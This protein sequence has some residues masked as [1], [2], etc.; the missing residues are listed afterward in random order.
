MFFM[1]DDFEKI[2]ISINESI[3]TNK[4][5][6]DIS[7]ILLRSRYEKYNDLNISYFGVGDSNRTVRFYDPNK[8]KKKGIES[9]KYSEIKIGKFIRK[10]LTILGE[11]DNFD[12]KD[13]E[14][15]T[16]TYKSFYD[17]NISRENGFELMS[18]TKG[19]RY[20]YDSHNFE[21]NSGILGGSCMNNLEG[22]VNYYITH[23]QGNLR[24]LVLKN[25]DNK[26]LGRALVWKTDKGL[27]MDRVYTINDS[28][29]ELFKRYAQKKKWLYKDKQT[30]KFTRT[31]G[32]SNNYRSPLKFVG[33]NMTVEVDKMTKKEFETVDIPYIDTFKYFYWQQGI[34]SNVHNLEGYFIELTH[35]EGKWNCNTC[36]GDGETEILSKCGECSGFGIITDKDG[37]ESECDNC[38][39]SSMVDC[40]TCGGLED[41]L[42]YHIV[43]DDE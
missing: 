36:Y 2:I 16:N 37:D 22:I 5:I 43:H 18:P 20:A 13:I 15:F 35:T 40:P 17:F 6:N 21:S 32:P 12:D 29:I 3:N 8:V 24:V 4:S 31:M 41:G 9:L 27:F 26:L 34:L 11:F 33:F 42:P 39:P 28:D 30:Y 38:E 14:D 19:I 23:T 1:I 25:P 10:I 7:S